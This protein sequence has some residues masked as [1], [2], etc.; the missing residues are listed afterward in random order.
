[1]VGQVALSLV[2]VV[3]ALLFVRSLRNLLTLDAGFQRD[4]VLVVSVDLRRAASTPGRRIAEK[5]ELLD[6]MRAIPG[7]DAA[8]S[9]RIVPVSGGG[10]NDNVITDGASGRKPKVLVDCD[11]VSAGFFRT[12]GTPIAGGAATSTR[13]TRQ[14]RRRWRSSTRHSCGRSSAQ[15]GPIG[16]TFRFESRP[17]DPAPAY[18]IVGLVKDM[19][20]NDLRES[21]PPIA[22][23]P[24]TQNDAPGPFGAFLVRSRLPLTSL[25]P[26]RSSALSPM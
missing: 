12:L 15:G 20:Y 9:S 14:D 2:L 1:M 18:Q 6:R 25:T 10:W 4:G 3:G 23:F 17:G 7:V 19:K 13:T 5:R 21:F 8:A 22:Y 16:R 26:R 11:E 24:A